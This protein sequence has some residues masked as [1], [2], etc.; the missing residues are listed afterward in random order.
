MHCW[1]KED[2]TSSSHVFLPSVTSPLLSHCNGSPVLSSVNQRYTLHQQQTVPVSDV[3]LEQLRSDD[4]Q[5]PLCLQQ[6]GRQARTDKT[7]ESV[8]DCTTLHV[9]TQQNIVNSRSKASAVPSQYKDAAYYEK[10]RKNNESAKK[11]REARQHKEQ[12]I[13]A[14][15]QILKEE[16]M[17]L[18]AENKLLNRQSRELLARLYNR[19][20]EHKN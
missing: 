10:R 2:H 12:V 5:A 7:S 6:T 3:T 15:V 1:R 4:C 17:R 16:N 13:V 18:K 8:V 14:H 11:S 9:A 20:S 19:S